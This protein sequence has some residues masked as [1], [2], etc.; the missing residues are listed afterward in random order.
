MNQD[1]HFLN[2]TPKRT[3]KQPANLLFCLVA[4]LVTVLLT[5]PFL[6]LFTRM[7]A[8]IGQLIWQTGDPGQ[9]G[10][11]S[12]AVLSGLG[13]LVKSFGFN[14]VLLARSLGLSLATVGLTCLLGWLVALAIWIRGGSRANL[15]AAV[16][17]LLILVPP[18]IHV[19]AWIFLLDWI[20]GPGRNFTGAPAV[21]LTQSL[22]WLPLAAGLSLIAL[23]SVPAEQADLCRLETDSWSTFR[24]VYLP[25]QW[26]LLTIAG[27]LIWL[28][29]STDYG[30]ASV[31]GVPTLA[32]DLF[33]R[34]S[35]G[36]PLETVVL[37]A[38]PLLLASMLVLLLMQ[39]Q[40]PDWLPVHDLTLT[41]PAAKVN[42]FRRAPWLRHLARPGLVILILFV[43]VPLL[44]LGSE[45]VR[46]GSRAA[47]QNTL[48]A[49][50]QLIY[51]LL[52]SLLAACFGLLPALLLLVLRMRLRPARIRQPASQTNDPRNCLRPARRLHSTSQARHLFRLSSSNDL[53]TWLQAA[54]ILPILLPA[55]ICGLALI[56]FYNQGP[57]VAL[58]QSP[59]MPAFALACRFCLIEAVILQAAQARLDPDLLA[60]IR[61][62][63]IGPMSQIRLLLPCLGR[64]VLASL[65]IVIAFSMGEFGITLLVTPPGFQ[66]LSIKIYNYLHYGASET[67]AILCLGMLLI[68]L[69]LIAA[70]Y[71]LLTYREKRT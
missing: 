41:S 24:H 59:L 43:A 69:A 9:A 38:W 63:G 28:M 53:H 47:W 34:F 70:V 31:F 35:A 27:M 4:G 5:A 10:R 49:L 11:D 14:P 65:L 64:E 40:I 6:V 36:D 44:S 21:I 17:L 68:V 56:Y 42:P 20:L 13:N 45:A 62:D 16:M 60:A 51:S 58:Y 30:I 66:T 67:V 23:I 46:G 22:A 25:A 50:P 57:G 61:L 26:P 37:A 7:F 29:Q 52:T 54:M 12:L 39:K 1:L 15:A 3:P 32:L 2:R 71:K 55:P 8:Y 18:F 33:A 48:S 19:Q